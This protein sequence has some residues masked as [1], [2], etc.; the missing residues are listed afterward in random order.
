M[1]LHTN[2]QKKHL[3]FV[4]T[5]HYAVIAFANR[6]ERKQVLKGSTQVNRVQIPIFFTF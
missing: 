5:V 4:N 6:R 2:L 1:T 3:T